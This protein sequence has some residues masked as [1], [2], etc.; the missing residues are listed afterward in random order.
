MASIENPTSTSCNCGEIAG[1]LLL[2]LWLGGRALLSGIEKFSAEVTVQKPLLLDNGAPD[3][4]GAMLEVEEKVYGFEHYQ[5][6][7]DALRTS[8]AAQPL[9][10]SFL[11][12]P[13]YAS[14]GYILIILGIA[15]LIGLKTRWTLT[16]MGVLYTILTFGLILIKQDSGVAWLGIHLALIVMAL[17][18][19]KHNRY[20]LT[21]S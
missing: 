14:L 17:Q 10:P 15:L 6:V 1:F 9:L 3:P 21:R 16:A 7:P 2:R 18:L 5:G 13:F 4:S 12:T 11:T 8:F 19:Y 20:A